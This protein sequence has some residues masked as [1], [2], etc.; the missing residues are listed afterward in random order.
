MPVLFMLMSVCRSYNIIRFRIRFIY[1]FYF[2]YYI[3][4]V[5]FLNF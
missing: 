4:S 5:F 3:F 1:P 2:I